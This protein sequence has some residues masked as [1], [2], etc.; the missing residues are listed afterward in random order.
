MKAIDPQ[1]QA[2]AEAGEETELCISCL[3]PNAPGTTFCAHCGTPLTSYAATGPFESMLA[4][5]DLWR[6]AIRG[7]RGKPWIRLVAIGF[8]VFLVMAILSGFVIPR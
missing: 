2:Q 1:L 8:L 5:G 7:I 4:E 6:K 3:K